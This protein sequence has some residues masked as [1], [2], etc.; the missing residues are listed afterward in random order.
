MTHRG[1]EDSPPEDPMSRAS[2][3][4]RR[5][6]RLR[7]VQRTAILEA[8]EEVF[9]ERGYLEAK[10]AEIARRAGFSAGS[11]YNYFSGKE[12]IFVTLVT[13]QLEGLGDLLTALLDQPGDFMDLIQ[14]VTAAYASF[15]DERRR[16]FLI[17]HRTFPALV[18]GPASSS[19]PTELRELL[20]V[21]G[22]L[23]QRFTVLVTRI[24]ARGME[25]GQ[26]RQLDPEPLAVL[27]IGMMDSLSQMWLLEEPPKPF[28]QSL[29][30]ALDIFLNGVRV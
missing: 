26:L 3:R 13:D 2:P 11:L 18:W 17:I 7:E 24:L 19:T 14:R 21:K 22:D 5:M 15:M 30:F 8:A 23:Y 6:E 27:L 29:P 25:E 10:V 16:L 9:A 1:R 4:Q 28:A 20:N 12:D